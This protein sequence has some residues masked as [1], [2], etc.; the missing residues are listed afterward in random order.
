MILYLADPP[1]TMAGILNAAGT[2]TLAF[3]IALGGVLTGIKGL[4]VSRQVKETAIVAK[5]TAVHVEKIHTLVDG[6]LTASIEATLDATRRELVVL[7][8]VARLH[9]EAGREQDPETRVEI[10][11]TTTKVA[12]LEQQIVKRRALDKATASPPT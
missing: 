12:E 1:S 9:E 5:E 7:R 3:M 8:E 10:A 4:R 6:N 2:W 11:R